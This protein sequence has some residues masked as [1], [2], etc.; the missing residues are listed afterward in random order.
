MSENKLNKLID[1]SI[2]E[3]NHLWTS[4]LVLVGGSTTILIQNGISTN[5]LFAIAGLF[6]SFLVFFLYLKKSIQIDNFINKLEN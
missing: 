1:T 6:L 5:G 3:R 4:F 2:D